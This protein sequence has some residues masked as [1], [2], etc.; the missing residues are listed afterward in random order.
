MVLYTVGAL[1]LDQALARLSAAMGAKGAAA[2]LPFA[3]AAIDVD[4]PED[5]ALV[6]TIVAKRGS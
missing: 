2:I 5:L 3:E 6:E 1:T 4:K